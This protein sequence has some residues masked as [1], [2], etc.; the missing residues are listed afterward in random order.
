MLLLPEEFSPTSNVRRAKSTSWSTTDL[1]LPNDTLLMKGSVFTGV[2]T[3]SDIIILPLLHKKTQRAF[4]Y[5]EPFRVSKNRFQ[6][7]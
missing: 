7:S 1:K 4:H 2:F 5:T 6:Q 3:S